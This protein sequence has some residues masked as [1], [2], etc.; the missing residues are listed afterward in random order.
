MT[1][2]DRVQQIA[3]VSQ[4]NAENSHK[5]TIFIK[6]HNFCIPLSLR[7]GW[8][9]I[10]VWENSKN[11]QLLAICSCAGLLVWTQPLQAA[12][13]LHSHWSIQ[14]T[15]HVPT[16]DRLSLSVWPC[17]HQKLSARA[18][19]WQLN[20]F[21]IF[22]NCRS[23]T[24]KAE[25][26]EEMTWLYEHGV[27]MAILCIALWHESDLWD[28]LVSSHPPSFVLSGETTQQTTPNQKLA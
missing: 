10:L 1:A 15:G 19:R 14:T 6:P 4:R 12:R 28:S 9:A 18:D 24:R 17:P 22:Q 26:D 16:T 25:C 20:V 23:I 7:G 21:L 3:L 27:F 2:D 8:T 5:N 11:I 13:I